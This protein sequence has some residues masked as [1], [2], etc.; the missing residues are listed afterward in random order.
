MEW[1]IVIGVL[2]IGYFYLS[3]RGKNADLSMLPE[4][5]IVLDLETTGLNPTKNEIIEI[6]AVKVN[7][8]SNHHTTFQALVKPSKKVPKKITEL[9]GITQKM[10]DSEGEDIGTVLK[11]FMDF[12]GDLRL[13]T[14]NAEFDMGF[15]MEASKS[16]GLRINNPVSCALKMARRAWPSLESYKLADLANIGGI[17]SKGNHRALKDCELTIMVYTA[18]ASKLGSVK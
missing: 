6:G 7:R 10:V 4:Q 15:L 18:A 12:I 14:F 16:H 2:V 17:S 13:V 1:L 11:E 9:T 3:S 8:D 5:F